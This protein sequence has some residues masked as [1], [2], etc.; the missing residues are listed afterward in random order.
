M[1]RIDY[2][3]GDGKLSELLQEK[4][5]L[6][7]LKYDSYMGNKKYISKKELKIASFD[8]VISTSV[9]EHLRNRES[10]NE[11]ASLVSSNGVMGI[12]TIVANEIPCDPNWFYLLP[13]H[14]SFYTN[15]S[16]EILF[17]NWNYSAS[18]YHVDS[19]LWFWFKTDVDRVE[20]IINNAN[21]LKGRKELHYH[22]KHGF[23]DYWKLKPEE[24]LVRTCQRQ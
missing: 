17:N 4:Y 21:S 22:F 15:R 14:C 16:M 20:K 7:L 13:V 24:V 5:N 10:L 2:G 19:Q 23:I 1:V 11:I 3:C 6:K 12:H 9:F 18:I 8:F